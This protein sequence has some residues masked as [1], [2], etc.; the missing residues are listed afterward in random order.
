SVGAQ[1]LE[2]RELELDRHARP[3]RGLDRRA[4]VARDRVR[5]QPPPLG[6]ILDRRRLGPDR[7]LPQLGRV[8]VEAEDDLAAALLDER[9]NSICEMRQTVALIAFF[10]AEPALN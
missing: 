7:D 4:A 10:S 3:A 8:G 9:R 6:E 5:G 1:P 2:A